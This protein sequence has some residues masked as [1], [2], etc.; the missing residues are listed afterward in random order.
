MHPR[1]Q[2]A[3]HWKSHAVELHGNEKRRQEVDSPADPRDFVHIRTLRPMSFPVYRAERAMS[4][5]LWFVE[6][7]GARAQPASVVE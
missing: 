1:V 5:V 7:R 6:R 3:P 2:G 4:I